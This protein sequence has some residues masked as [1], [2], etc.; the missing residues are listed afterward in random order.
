MQRMNPR[1]P[2]KLAL[3]RSC[4]ERRSRSVARVR[5]CSAGY[6]AVVVDVVCQCDGPGVVGLLEIVQVAHAVITIPYETMQRAFRGDEVAHDLTTRV[7]AR[8]RAV[9]VCR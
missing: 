2:R 8:G 3:Q 5:G 1:Y 6:H 7:D 9:V 4:H